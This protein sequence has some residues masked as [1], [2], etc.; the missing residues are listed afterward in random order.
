MAP[1][2]PD[3]PGKLREMGFANYFK[4]LHAFLHSSAAVLNAQTFGFDSQQYRSF[5]RVLPAAV[6]GFTGEFQFQ[7]WRTYEELDKDAFEKID[8]F[9]VD[10]A[11]KIFDASQKESTAF[12]HANLDDLIKDLA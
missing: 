5:R 6:Q 8:D 1:E 3:V 10:Y 2:A 4:N 12:R 9:L 7:L 11:V